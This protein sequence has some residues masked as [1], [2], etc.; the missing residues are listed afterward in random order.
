[1]QVERVGVPE[2]AHG[3]QESVATNSLAA[4][5]VRHHLSIR[6]FLHTLHLRHSRERANGRKKERAREENKKTVRPCKT[7]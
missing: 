5:Q 6:P 4:Q 2:T 1:M 7:Q 3:V